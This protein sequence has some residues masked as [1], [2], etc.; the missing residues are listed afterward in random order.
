VSNWYGMPT[1]GKSCDSTVQFKYAP[2]QSNYSLLN[3]ESL[4]LYDMVEMKGSKL[5]VEFVCINIL[6]I[7]LQGPI[8]WK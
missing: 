3:S 2:F 4:H 1:V 7:L 6:P 5:R 8:G